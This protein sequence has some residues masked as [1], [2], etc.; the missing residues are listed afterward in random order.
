MDIYLLSDLYLH[1]DCPKFVHFL[2]SDERSYRKE[3][4]EIAI[5]RMEKS[6]I[7]AQMDID[8]F[9]DL[10]QR[11]EEC[12]IKLNKTEVDYGEIPDEFRDPLMD[13]LMKDPVHLPTSGKI[14]DRS[15]IARHLLNSSTDP[16][17]RQKLTENMLEPMPDLK[18][19]IQNW[20]SAKESAAKQCKE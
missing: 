18:E 7:K 20:I 9:R 2:A 3:L 8:H 12:R 16:F 10:A 11:V 14:M 15:I 4:Y 6:A 5:R 13:T 1:L 17:N 19:K